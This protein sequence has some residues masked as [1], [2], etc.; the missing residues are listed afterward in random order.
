MAPYKAARAVAVLDSLWQRWQE[1]L[2]LPA[3]VE[4]SP[5]HANLLDGLGRAMLNGEGDAF[6]ANDGAG[7][8][9]LPGLFY[10]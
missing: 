1:M 6:A 5:T 9:N 7:A 8:G 4:A 10:Q 2:K 3:A